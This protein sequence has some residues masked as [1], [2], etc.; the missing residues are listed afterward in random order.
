[1]NDLLLSPVPMSQL[2]EIIENA[3]KLAVANYDNNKPQQPDKDELLTQKQASKLLN[4]SIVT[5]IEW[6]KSGRI[7]YHKINSRV[8]YRKNEVLESMASFN[9]GK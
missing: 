8:Y 7:P 3:V 1:M 5:L 2:I 9:N 4:V 6:K